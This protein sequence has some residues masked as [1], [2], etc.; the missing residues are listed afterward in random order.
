MIIL[1]ETT[2]V[3]PSCLK[4]VNAA[5]VK[6]QGAV[7]LE[8]ECAKHGK[9]SC[10]ISNDA[11]DFENWKT[12][13]INI[14]PKITLQRA[15]NGCPHDCGPCENHLQTACCVLIDITNRCNQKCAVCFA[16]ASPYKK[17][18]PGLPEREPSLQEIEKKYDELIRMSE[19]RKFNIQISGGEPTVRED[20][21]EI[22]KMA[23]AKRF[24]YV[25]L[26]T[27]GKRI[28][29]EENYAQ[30]LKQA[31]VD[32]VFMQFDSMTDSVYME[33]RNEKLLAI[34]KNAIENCRKAGF[35]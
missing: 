32:A 17:Q 23:K 24:E 5:Y 13:A 11:H 16:S 26:N 21:P 4:S 3:C 1:S 19:T 15:K 9:S 20:L 31:G 28:G 25:Q 6:K 34:K 29:I 30:E 12:N 22:V 33:M 14:K 2:S 7:Y 27:N 18:G 8:K 35:Q 10:L